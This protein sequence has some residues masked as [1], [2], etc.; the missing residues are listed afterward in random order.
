MQKHII[1]TTAVRLVSGAAFCAPNRSVSADSV[2]S[3]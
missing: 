1:Y 3:C 2:D